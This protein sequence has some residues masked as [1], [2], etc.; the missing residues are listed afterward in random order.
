M[1][2]AKVGTLS[3]GERS[4]LLL[5]RE[6]A[7]PSNLMV[8]D[9]PTNDLD[10]STLELLEDRLAAYRGTVLLVSH[11]R[12]FLDNVVTSV[13]VFEKHSPDRPG[14]WLGPEQ[15]WYVNE[16]VGGYEDWAQRRVLPPA[17]EPEK[18]V[19]PPRERPAAPPK[20]KRLSEAEKRELASAPKRIEALE[21]EQAELLAMMADPAF[22][23]RSSDEALAQARAR[24]DEL[25]TE[26]E[27]AYAR[28]E[29]LE[30]AALGVVP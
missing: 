7:R 6:F 13:L 24:S 4:R 3:G 18:K 17:P 25:V 23:R 1:V 27:S 2:E 28:W 8:L 14:E 15:G 20:K 30:A 10:L 12:A 5:A 22:Y 16:Y 11:D 26:I 21:T 29:A 19:V 9:E